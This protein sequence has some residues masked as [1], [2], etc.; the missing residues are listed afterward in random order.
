M[1]G[2]LTGFIAFDQSSV[3][4]RGGYI[5]TLLGPERTDVLS[6]QDND[7]IGFPVIPI[8]VFGWGAGVGIG[9]DGVCCLRTAQWTRASLLV[10]V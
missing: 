3:V 4:G 10:S 1:G 7:P 6:R 9:F 5:D 2:T 8:S